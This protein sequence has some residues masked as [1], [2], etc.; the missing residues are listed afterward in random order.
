[1]H[2]IRNGHS[3]IKEALGRNAARGFLGAVEESSHY[4]LNFREGEAVY[5]SENTLFYGLLTARAWREEPALYEELL[6]LQDTTFR[7]REWGYHFPTDEL[8]GQALDAVAAAFVGRGGQAMSRT[9]DG[10]DMEAT[11]LREGLPFVI[12]AD[13]PLPEGWTQ[14]AQRTSQSEKGLARWEVT[15]S[16]QE[17]KEDAER[18]IHE[19]VQRY[20]AGPRY[21]G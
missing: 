7:A 6:E 17:R 9:A 8:R 2:V 10:M 15:A 11:L 19:T 14:V 1:V 5:P 20:Q 4:Y 13:T 18:L 21:V 16:T 3:Q 12:D